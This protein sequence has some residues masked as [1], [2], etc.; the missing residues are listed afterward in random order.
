VQDL[1]SKPYFAWALRAYFYITIAIFA[2]SL[3][4]PQSRSQLLLDTFW[5][6]GLVP[7][8]GYVKQIPLGSATF[9]RT[10]LGLSLLVFIG[11]FIYAFYVVGS[12][13]RPALGAA[14]KGLALA[15][16]FIAPMWWANYLY[17]FRSPHLWSA[18]QLHG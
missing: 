5:V 11:Q 12:E 8:Y 1:T 10:Y 16:V 13:I 18:R 17:A 3:F 9:W 7:L 4:I 15:V 6:I 14:L 2:L